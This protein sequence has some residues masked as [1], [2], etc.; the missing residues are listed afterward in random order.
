MLMLL[1]LML[2]FWKLCSCVQFIKSHVFYS[3]CKSCENP[4]Q[5]THT[6]SERA[7]KSKV[8]MVKSLSPYYQAIPDE[9]LLCI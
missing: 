3:A 4:Y 9:I 2:I 6:M 1:M 7:M 8:C 5:V